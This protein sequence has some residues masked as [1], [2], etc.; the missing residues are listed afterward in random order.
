MEEPLPRFPL[1]RIVLGNASL[2]SAVYLA[3]AV[4]VE[5]VRRCCSLRWSERASFAFESLPAR[6]LELLGALPELRRLYV[7]GSLSEP[8]LRLLFG[9]TSVAIIFL[10]ALVVGGG[11]WLLRAGWERRVR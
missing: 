1:W 2:L 3:A 7:Y 9:L 8:W 6:A 10:L 4:G 5:A 11:M